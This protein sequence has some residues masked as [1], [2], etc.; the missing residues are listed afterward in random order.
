MASHA[1]VLS[2]IGLKSA[3]D[4]FTTS[5]NSCGLI[6]WSCDRLADSITDSFLALRSEL[7]DEPA[8]KRAISIHISEAEHIGV[9]NA[10]VSYYPYSDIEQGKI[11]I[12]KRL[13]G[14]SE[15][16]FV[17]SD[18]TGNAA[19]EA[20]AKTAYYV[21]NAHILVRLIDEIKYSDF[22]KSLRKIYP[23]SYEKIE[24]KAEPED[25]RRSP[26]LIDSLVTGIGAAGLLSSLLSADKPKKKS[27]SPTGHRDELGDMIEISPVLQVENLFANLKKLAADNSGNRLGEIAGI[28]K[29]TL[30]DSGLLAQLKLVKDKL[31]EARPDL[32]EIFT[33]RQCNQ[34]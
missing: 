29:D 34:K 20:S 5:L 31:A 11:Y 24:P 13:L 12:A 14:F 28:I 1:K 30:V 10:L 22:E 2:L 32:L 7:G 23:Y 25:I 27:H 16:R 18:M 6:A 8:L 15:Q 17:F 33:S 26:T 19:D 4:R 21:S 3:L 9:P